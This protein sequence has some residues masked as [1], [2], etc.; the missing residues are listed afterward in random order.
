VRRTVCGVPYAD[1]G[2]GTAYYEVHGQGDPVVLL[3]G[4]LFGFGAGLLAP[5]IGD[6]SAQFTVY[7]PERVGHGRTPDRDGP[8]SYEAMADETAAFIES[9]VGQPAHLVGWSDGMNVAIQTLLARPE[10]VERLVG[11]G[12]SV[13]P[14]G[15]IIDYVAV[16][17]ELR[18]NP[19]PSLVESYAN[20]SPD[21]PEHFAD[22]LEKGTMLWLRPVHIEFA[23][24]SAVQSAV[25]LIQ[26]DDD[27][28]RVEHTAAA[29]HAFP[30]GHLAVLPGSH[31]LPMESP[32][33]LNPLIIAFLRGETPPAHE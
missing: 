17:A 9:V 22:F 27:V 11:I 15:D 13:H 12:S 19:W 16:G 2:F 3:H 20:L 29:A 25:L 6:L 33:I 18:A 14:D 8:Y 21:G 30:R 5:Q 24:L 7:T 26:G 4:G 10:L 32:Q 1:V 31:L 23:Q 28:V